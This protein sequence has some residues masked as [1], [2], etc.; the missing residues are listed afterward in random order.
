MVSTRCLANSLKQNAREI[1]LRQGSRRRRRPREGTMSRESSG[2]QRSS[3]RRDLTLSTIFSSVKSTKSILFMKREFGDER[4]ERPGATHTCLHMLALSANIRRALSTENLVLTSCERR[5]SA[6]TD[7]VLHGGSAGAS[8]RSDPSVKVVTIAV[9]N[10]T[11]D[12]RSC[13]EQQRM[14]IGATITLTRRAGGCMSAE[15]RGGRKRLSA[16]AG[17]GKTDERWRRERSRSM[18]DVS[19]YRHTASRIGSR[20]PFRRACLHVFMDTSV[21]TEREEGKYIRWG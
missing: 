1:I 9:W 16:R 10:Q 15:G 14:T 7:R 13:D 19:I 8:A 18:R 2:M 3:R 12:V 11:V 4:D 21:A 17:V 6:T 20:H 5:R